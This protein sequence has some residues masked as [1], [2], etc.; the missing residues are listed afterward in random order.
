MD[1][2][3]VQM[4]NKYDSNFDKV[5]DYDEFQNFAKI[6]GVT[7]KMLMMDIDVNHDGVVSQDEVINYL[8]A[9]TSGHQLAQIFNQYA[10]RKKDSKTLTMTPLNLQKFF[11]QIQE[12]PIS[13]LEAYQLVITF[14]SG[15]DPQIKKG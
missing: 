7:P 8:K 3:L 15:I 4:V 10:S 5:F 2:Q 11:I 12:E 14:T 13:E 1:G 9:K 6:L